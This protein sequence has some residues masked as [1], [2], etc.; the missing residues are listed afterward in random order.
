MQLFAPHFKRRLIERVIQAE[1]QDAVDK[2]IADDELP[3]R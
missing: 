2:L 3:L 1:S